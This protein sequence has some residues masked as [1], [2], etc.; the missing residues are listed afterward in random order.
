M[1]VIIKT[2]SLDKETELKVQELIVKTKDYKDY[3][4]VVRSAIIVLYRLKIE[5]GDM[6]YDKSNE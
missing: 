4:H 5:M 6:K 3:S 2:I 1:M